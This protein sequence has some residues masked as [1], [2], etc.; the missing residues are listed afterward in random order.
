MNIEILKEKLALLNMPELGYDTIDGVI[1]I[2]SKLSQDYISDNRVVVARLFE[3]IV[4]NIQELF[5]S[6]EYNITN[7]PKEVQNRIIIFYRHIS[8][9]A[10]EAS[11]EEK[12]D[13][14]V[15]FV[16]FLRYL[17]LHNS[18]GD[19]PVFDESVDNVKQYVD[20][21]SDLEQVRFIFEIRDKDSDVRFFPI[22]ELLIYVIK[23]AKFLTKTSGLQPF[24]IRILGY[25]SRLFKKGSDFSKDLECIIT[26][27]NLRFVDYLKMSDYLADN[28]E[29]LNYRLNGSMTFIKDGTEK[30][31]LIRSNH[32][33]YFLQRILDEYN[34]E[35]QEEKTLDGNTIGWFVEKPYSYNSF[36][37]ASIMMLNSLYRK[38]VLTLFFKGY[39]NIF[40]EKSLIQVADDSFE[41]VNPFCESD[42]YVIK[43]NNQYARK[44]KVLDI[45]KEYSNYSLFTSRKYFFNRVFIG[46]FITLMHLGDA[47][48][49]K[50]MEMQFN[51]DDFY[52]NQLII[53]W[54]MN[55]SDR[56]ESLKQILG[57]LCKQLE[58]CLRLDVKENQ[59]NLP[60]IKDHMIEPQCFFRFFVK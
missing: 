17:E 25:A 18:I 40:V 53:N 51:E 33:K 41:L 22:E 30:K 12:K 38:Q 57:L 58:Y 23:D 42:E 60:C 5:C 1:D 3:Q 4:K 45:F 16:S 26:K 46:T 50:Y 49:D 35:L 20:T 6:S 56:L 8:A 14:S 21:L 54:I 10:V 9:I 36:T 13:G 28:K 44:D 39:S 37:D 32:K 47:S 59:K 19:V 43:K 55:Q 52:Q 27:C 29:L 7:I 15:L 48:P 24:H 34:L 11:D 2:I 31:V